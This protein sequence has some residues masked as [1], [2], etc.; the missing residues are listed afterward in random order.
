MEILPSGTA[1]YIAPPRGM[2]SSVDKETNKPSITVR[3]PSVTE[4]MRPERVIVQ[5]EKTR[6]HNTGE[7][8]NEAIRIFEGHRFSSFEVS[9]QETNIQ[10]ILKVFL[11]AG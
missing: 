5:A 7:T 1:T 4:V 2:A 6:E 10:N 11:N 8:K 3:Q 9:R